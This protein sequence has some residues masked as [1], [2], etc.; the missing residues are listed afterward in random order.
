MLTWASPLPF[1]PQQ[2]QVRIRPQKAQELHKGQDQR[3]QRQQPQQQLPA[4][5]CPLPTRLCRKRKTVGARP[6]R[7]GS[8]PGAP[9]SE[10]PK[11]GLHLCP[12]LHHGV[13]A[14]PYCVQDC[15]GVAIEGMESWETAVGRAVNKICEGMKESLTAVFRTTFQGFGGALARNK[16]KL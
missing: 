8:P 3:A 4:H 2:G 1:S 5:R 6:L 7:G 14:R 9:P 15:R 10:S 11:V 13:S 12:G 16:T